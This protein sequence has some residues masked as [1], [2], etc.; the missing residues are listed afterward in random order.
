M[1]VELEAQAGRRRQHDTIDDELRAWTASREVEPLVEELRGLGIPASEVANGSTLLQKNPQFQARGY[2]ER[3]DHPTVGALPI[4]SLPFR[5][6]SVDRW[7]RRPAP[8]LGQHNEEI[9]GEILGLSAEALEKLRA[10]GVIGTRP[11]GL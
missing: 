7:H 5:F 9:L 11:E 8:T 3:T 1:N 10:E 2:F 4:P 6:A